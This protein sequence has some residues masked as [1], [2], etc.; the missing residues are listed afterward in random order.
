ARGRGWVT[1]LQGS[2]DFPATAS[3]FDRTFG[4]GRDD[5]FV[6]KFGAF[7][8]GL[9]YSTLLGGT[10][11]DEPGGIAIDESGRAYVAGSTSSSDYPTTRGAFDPTFNS[12]PRDSEDAFVTKLRLSGSTL[13]Y[14]T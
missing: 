14:S 6:T 5:V 1:G 10:G 8:A 11:D 13:A 4:G 12:V 7:G 2:V 9:I 3:A